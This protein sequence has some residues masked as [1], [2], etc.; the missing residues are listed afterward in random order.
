MDALPSQRERERWGTR[1][2]SAVALFAI[3][4]VVVVLAIVCVIHRRVQKGGWTGLKTRSTCIKGQRG[5]GPDSFVRIESVE[6]LSD[7][8]WHG[9]DH[10]SACTS[11]FILISRRHTDTRP[12]VR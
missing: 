8:P 10:P 6:M 5:E 7:G 4:V 2:L 12:L 11:Q 1:Y 9:V 3:I